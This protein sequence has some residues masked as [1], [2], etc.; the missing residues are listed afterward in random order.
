MWTATTSVITPFTTTSHRYIYSHRCCR[1]SGYWFCVDFHS[2]TL[3]LT[4]THCF[5]FHQVCMFFFLSSSFQMRTSTVVSFYSRYHL[6]STWMWLKVSTFKSGFSIYIHWIEIETT[7]F[8][9][10]TQTCTLNEIGQWKKAQFVQYTIQ[11]IVGLDSQMNL[12][13]SF[14]FVHFNKLYFVFDR[15]FWFS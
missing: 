6:R 2:L 9:T 13:G 7:D 14:I 3:S 15:C 5:P 1:R 10:H 12:V 8:E 4:H 11:R